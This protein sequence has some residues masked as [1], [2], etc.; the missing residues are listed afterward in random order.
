MSYYSA[1]PADVV[2]APNAEEK[3]DAG[4]APCAVCH[5][6]QDEAGAE[7]LDHGEVVCRGCITEQ[8]TCPGCGETL[9][10][11]EFVGDGRISEYCGPCD[12][13]R[14]RDAGVQ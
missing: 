4:L 1:N 5:E 7:E 2:G 12:Y 8:V 13:R 9:P 3:A 14:D 10:R 11:A 6:W